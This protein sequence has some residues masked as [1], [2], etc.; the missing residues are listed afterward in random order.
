MAKGKNLLRVSSK[1]QRLFHFRQNK[2]PAIAFIALTYPICRD[3]TQWLEIKEHL[4][5]VWFCLRKGNS[6]HRGDSRSSSSHSALGKH[7]RGALICENLVTNTTI[8]Q[9]VSV[10]FKMNLVEARALR[11]RGPCLWLRWDLKS[12]EAK[13]SLSVA[14]YGVNCT[15][16][17]LLCSDL[18][19]V[20]CSAGWLLQKVFLRFLYSKY[21]Y[22]LC[23]PALFYASF[24]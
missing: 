3:V 12:A 6:P 21:I 4:E 1:N 15:K 24:N 8:K 14:F 7:D 20:I 2:C 11:W 5:L 17:V 10:V 9:P 23:I 16:P 13:K 18:V 22:S 19:L